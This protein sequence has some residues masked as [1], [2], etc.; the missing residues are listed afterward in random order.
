MGPFRERKVPYFL[1]IPINTLDSKREL[2]LTYRCLGFHE[3]LRATGVAP[4][5]KT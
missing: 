3:A 4:E 5:R 1:Q 2:G